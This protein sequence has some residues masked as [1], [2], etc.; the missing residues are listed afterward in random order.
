MDLYMDLKHK[1]L[2]FDRKQME[3]QIRKNGDRE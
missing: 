2:Y 1:Y 3:E